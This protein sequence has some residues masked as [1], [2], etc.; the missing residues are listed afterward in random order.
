MAAGLLGFVESQVNALGK[1]IRRLEVKTATAHGRAH[2][3]V[4]LVGLRAGRT[5]PQVSFEL[6][7][8]EQ[9][10]LAVQVSVN[11]GVIL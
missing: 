1:I 2:R 4:I 6:Q 10:E 8:A 3:L 9:I 11:Q 5:L 7:R